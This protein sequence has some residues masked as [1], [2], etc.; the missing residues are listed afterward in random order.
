MTASVAN[1]SII[2]DVVQLM[3]RLFAETFAGLV[4]AGS[5]Q[6]TSSTPSYRHALARHRVGIDIRQPDA[7]RHDFS[8]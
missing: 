6:S 8:P 7:R 5:S 2:S 4:G 3:R 1:P